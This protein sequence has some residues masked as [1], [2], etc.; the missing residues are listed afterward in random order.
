M[1]D[2]IKQGQL[3]VTFHSHVDAHAKNNIHTQFGGRKIDEIP[4][5]NVDVIEIWAGEE[6][7]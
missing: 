5:L 2:L 4:Q 7:K 1:R 3:L 6:A